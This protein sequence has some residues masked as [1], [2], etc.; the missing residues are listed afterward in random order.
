VSAAET[1]LAAPAKPSS[2]IEQALALRQR[3][4]IAEAERVLRGVLAAEPDH[5]DARH[6]LGLICHQQG[7]NIEALQLVSALL[8]AAP[9][10][11]ELI[12]NCGLI[13]AA[14]TQHQVA[15]ACFESALALSADNLAA[16]KNRAGMLKRLRQP[17]QALAAYEAVLAQDA[18]DLDALNECGGLLTA[19]NRP[20]EALAYYQRALAVAPG[21]VE[22]H[23]NKGAALVALNRH[24]E[25]FE[26]FSAAIAIDPE[27]AEAQY[28]QSLVRLRLGNFKNGWPQFEWRW[29]KFVGAGQQRF[30]GAPLWRGDA[31]LADKTILLL[32]E[33]G[34][35]DSIHFMR[36]APLVAALG[37]RVVLGIQSPLQAIAGTV[38]GVALV[39]G[40]GEPLP[41]LDFHC[42]LLS[43]PLAFKTDRATVPA[44]VP[45]LRAPDERLAAWRGRVPANGRLRVGV[46]WA[47][48]AAHLN[49]RNRSIALARF[50]TL[51]TVPGVDF[52]SIQKETSE[53]ERALLRASG[54]VQLGAEC[55]DFA[56]TAAILSMLDLLISVDTSVAHLGGAMGKAVA[57]LLPFASDFRWLVDRADSPW[58]P[59]MRLY[60]QP[61]IGD[62][63]TPLD[64]LR[65]E[66][67]VV[68]GRADKSP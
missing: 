45:Y 38:P 7:R 48:S 17:E 2:P 54:V 65:Q 5:F 59:T 15:L 19:L 37:A 13:F 33:Q 9:H 14:L 67:A 40:E 64:R 30:S 42:P 23:I 3:G 12:N 28:N 60:R 68:A 63:E 1:A 44:N 49:D 36:Y 10:S 55:A 20:D 52:V 21:V 34:L 11:A 26:S 6:L 62:W 24:L 57:L 35:G 22:L 32:A 50:A 43:L 66:L 46:C 58:Y 61:A 41:P 29:K 39:A 56:D 25:A 16:L 31:P 51:L 27:R 4:Q 8:K 18:R 53:A 47:G